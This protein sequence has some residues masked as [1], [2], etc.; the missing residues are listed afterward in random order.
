MCRARSLYWNGLSLRSQLKIKGMSAYFPLHR[1]HALIVSVFFHSFFGCTTNSRLNYLPT[2]QS[3]WHPPGQAYGDFLS[4]CA[5]LYA[6]FVQVAISI[7][8]PSFSWFWIR[9]FTY[10]FREELWDIYV[11]LLQMLSFYAFFMLG[12]GEQFQ[13][14]CA[15]ISLVFSMSCPVTMLLPLYAF[16]GASGN[17]SSWALI[18]LVFNVYLRHS[19]S[20]FGMLSLYKWQFQF[21]CPYFFSVECL[22]VSS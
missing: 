7:L 6:A 20:V 13:F 10:R 15:L 21:L 2:S 5:L 3:C 8:G 9:L 22:F 11:I 19:N 4:N 16:F 18:C 12:E 1:T 17:C 14:S